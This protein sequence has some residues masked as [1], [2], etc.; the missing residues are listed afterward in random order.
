MHDALLR[1]ITFLHECCW[2]YILRVSR[3]GKMRQ[4]WQ[5]AASAYRVARSG[6]L[7]RKIDKANTCLREASAMDV[8]VQQLSRDITNNVTDRVRERNAALDR[9]I[10][11]AT[12][13][14]AVELDKKRDDAW[15]G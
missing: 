13:Q 5:R 11:D 10:A 3:A 2:P 14:V 9:A 1:I 7:D 15:R 4:W 12:A 6:V 8:R